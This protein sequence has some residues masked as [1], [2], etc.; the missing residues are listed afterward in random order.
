M[1]RLSLTEQQKAAAHDGLVREIPLVL[2]D[3]G[4]KPGLRRDGEEVLRSPT[5]YLEHSVESA[6]AY[7]RVL[8]GADGS[9]PIGMQLRVADTLGRAGRHQRQ[10]ERRVA[11]GPVL[12]KFRLRESL[13]PLRPEREHDRAA[14]PRGDAPNPAER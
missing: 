4:G 9:L 14:R 12:V 13:E 10:R 2:V 8:R 1:F 6:D 3:L 5:K 7:V 11:C